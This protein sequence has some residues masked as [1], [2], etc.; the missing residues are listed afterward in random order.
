MTE[1]CAKK[2]QTSQLKIIVFRIL[3]FRFFSNESAFHEEFYVI[4]ARQFF[5]FASNVPCIHFKN[6]RVLSM[7]THQLTV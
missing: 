3:A 2:E 5:E 6:T 1:F 7:G 4:F